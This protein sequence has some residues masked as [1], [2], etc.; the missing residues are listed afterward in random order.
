MPQ[1]KIDFEPIKFEPL[2]GSKIDFEPIKFEPIQK[3]HWYDSLIQ[4]PDFITKPARGISNFLNPNTGASQG[5]FIDAIKG[6]PDIARNTIAHPWETAKGFTG[7]AIEGAANLFSPLNIAQTIAP[8]LRA[9]KAISPLLGMAQAGIGASQMAGGNP[10]EGITN[11][12]FG[13]LGMRGIGSRSKMP[14]PEVLPSEFPVPTSIQEPLGLPAKGESTPTGTRFYNGSAGNVDSFRPYIADMAHN[15]HLTGFIPAEIPAID[16]AQHGLYDPIYGKTGMGSIEPPFVTEGKSIP[17]DVGIRS[18]TQM[19]ELAAI[20]NNEKG[21]VP[22]EVVPKDV[23]LGIKQPFNKPL[24]DKIIKEPSTLDKIINTGKEAAASIDLSAPLRQGLPLIHK[25]EFREALI[26]MV[27]AWA[28]KDSADLTLAEIQANKY[29]GLGQESGLSLTDQPHVREEVFKSDLLEKIP[30]LGEVFKSSNRAYSTFLNKLR[31]DTFSSLVDNLQKANPEAPIDL[32][33]TKELAKF[34]NSATGR[35]NLGPAERY[36]ELANTIFFSPR[37]VKSRVDMM[38]PMNYIKGSPEARKEYFKSFLATATA[39]GTV[40]GLA[41]VAGADINMDPT[42]SDFMKAKFGN[43]RVDPWGGFQSQLVAGARIADYLSNSTLPSTANSLG[44]NVE[45]KSNEY[46]LFKK[47]TLG[48][49]VANYS[50]GKFNPVI[51]F[52]YAMANNR[53]FN[54]LPFELKQSIMNHFAPMFLRDTYELAQEDPSLLPL[55]PLAAMGMG[56]QTY[57]PH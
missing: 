26:P 14:M 33:Q 1:S 8:E 45:D 25:K 12:G 55:A 47:P 9:T 21:T 48:T 23:A 28:S 32:T 31:Q 34:V 38:N 19:E 10:L 49:T 44:M 54:G 22:K 42:K 39:G 11:I 41:K 15:D 17:N 29:Y 43:T 37:F 40:L 3:S 27:K 56:M 6:I 52:A 4:A 46:G 50:S 57:Q 16:V 35:G 20:L 36:A 53:E 30:Y 2:G 5:G 7:G 51:S 18:K 13:A 24:T